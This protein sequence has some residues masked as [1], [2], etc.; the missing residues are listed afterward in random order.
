MTIFNMTPTGNQVR[1]LVNTQ[2]QNP[3]TLKATFLRPRISQ[4]SSPKVLAR[5]VECGAWIA[6]GYIGQALGAGL[7]FRV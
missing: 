7:G 1:G 6:F 3:E 4:A 2:I 5:A